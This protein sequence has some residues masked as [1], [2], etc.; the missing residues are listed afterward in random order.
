VVTVGWYSPAK[1][2]TAAGTH[3]RVEVSPDIVAVFDS[4][5]FDSALPLF[6]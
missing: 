6:D 5:F 2:V 4:L 3:T 1:G